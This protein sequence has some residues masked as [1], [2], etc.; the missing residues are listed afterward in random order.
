MRFSSFSLTHS[1]TLTLTLSHFY[2]FLRV[3]SVLDFGKPGG[4]L[5][6]SSSPPNHE[7]VRSNRFFWSAVTS[8]LCPGLP[9][10]VR[11]PSLGFAGM[12]GDLP[13]AAALLPALVGLPK[14][15]ET[16]VPAPS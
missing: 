11:H 6:F 7:P 2:F 9:G 5:F 14:S 13:P 1:L 15:T 16:E 8:G 12:L 3:F 10:G 4:A